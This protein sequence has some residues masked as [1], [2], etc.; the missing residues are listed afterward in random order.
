M[1]I[2]PNKFDTLR[3]MAPGRFTYEAATGFRDTKT[4]NAYD[5]VDDAIAAIAAEHDDS[6]PPVPT[7]TYEWGKPRME[8]GFP[9]MPFDDVVYVEQLTQEQSEGGIILAGGA[10]M[11]PMGRVVAVGPGRIYASAMNAAGTMEAAVFV[12]TRLQPGDLVV[13]GRYRTGGEK[14]EI[15]G[16]TYVACREGD[17]GGKL[18]RPVS[19]RV[20]KEA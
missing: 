6:M 3:K 9:I 17:L 20:I 1:A 13:W 2:T 16:K 8:E 15:E 4:G 10:E 12:P 19:I 14:M 18:E 5:D 7:R 11:M